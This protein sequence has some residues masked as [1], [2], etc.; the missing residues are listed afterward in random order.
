M[1]QNQEGPEFIY[2][3]IHKVLNPYNFGVDQRQAIFSK[4]TKNMVFLNLVQKMR[5]SSKK[6]KNNTDILSHELLFY[7]GYLN[8]KFLLYFPLSNLSR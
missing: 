1:I 6:A 7:Q 5:V 2:L 4:I 3:R 8:L